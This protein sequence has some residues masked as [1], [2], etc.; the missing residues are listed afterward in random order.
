MQPLPL[1]GD[2]LNA[3][4]PL[5]LLASPT[6]PTAAF[7]V[8]SNF[9]PPDLR[10]DE[11]TLTVGGAV[12][13]ALA[14]ESARLQRRPARALR[15]T[16]E[17]AGNGRTLADP[18]PPG[19]AWGL[20]AVGVAEF[21]G[22]P[23]A[24]LLR[25]VGP[26]ADAVEVLFEA[27]DGFQRSLPLAEAMREDVL[28]AWRMN[29]EPLT[30]E[31]GSPLRLVV[32]AWYGMASVKWL[33]RIEVLREPF[34]GPFQTE[35]YVYQGEEG[36][37]EGEPVRRIR[38]RSL[39]IAPLPG[40][41][42]HAGEVCEIRGLAWSGAGPVTG[43]EVT[44]DGGATWVPAHLQPSDSPYAPVSWRY[45]WPVAEAGSRLL[46]SRATD[47]AGHTQPSA[48]R[49]NRQGYGNNVV[50]WVPVTVVDG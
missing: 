41:T 24:E 49:W 12:D 30:R 4:T 26:A 20:G 16:F 42:L 9:D 19:T 32:P 23:L 45:A 27:A 6:T 14:L 17:C 22:A 31:H 33:R 37:P 25:E 46:G 28:L 47:S 18:R 39:L 5:S 44:V 36:T 7:F 21:E 50:Q 35:K 8:R 34:R 40:A 2:P 43:V 11:E 3:E 1:P 13:R 10:V 15:V 29:G 48:S 38:V